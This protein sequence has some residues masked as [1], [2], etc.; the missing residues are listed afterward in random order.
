MLNRRAK[1]HFRQIES[2]SRKVKAGVNKKV[3]NSII[4]WHN[5]NTASE[6]QAVQVR[7]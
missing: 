4:I 6:Q 3:I 1:V 7:R 2:K 5:S